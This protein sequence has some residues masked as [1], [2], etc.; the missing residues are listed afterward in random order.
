[1]KRVLIDARA[2]MVSMGNHWKHLAPSV[3]LKSLQIGE[4]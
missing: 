1:V 2:Q 4:I 3:R